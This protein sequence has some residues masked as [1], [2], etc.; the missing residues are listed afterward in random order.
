MQGPSLLWCVTHGG[1]GV[2]LE[3]PG[4][5][6]SCFLVEGLGQHPAS[7]PPRPRH[8]QGT[9]GARRKGTQ[10]GLRVIHVYAASSQGGSVAPES[11]D[12]TLWRG[13]PC[14]RC[15]GLH[16]PGTRHILSRWE[17]CVMPVPRPLAGASTLESEAVCKMD[18]DAPGRGQQ[19]D[20]GGIQSGHSM[21]WEEASTETSLEVGFLPRQARGRPSVDGAGVTCTCTCTCGPQRPRTRGTRPAWTSASSATNW[22]GPGSQAQATMRPGRG[23]LGGRAWHSPG[24]KQGPPAVPATEERAPEAGSRCEVSRCGRRGPAR[25]HAGAARRGSVRG[26]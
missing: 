4:L 9:Q 21:G 12:L 15:P 8:T 18:V 5:A 19:R 7:P 14:R 16:G 2:S 25:A 13:R 1:C 24:S 17:N 22:S 10:D 11:L 20:S 6:K 23:T 3:S 26:R